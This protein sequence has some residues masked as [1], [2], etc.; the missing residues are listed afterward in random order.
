VRKKGKGRARR[1]RDAGAS[2]ETSPSKYAR[3]TRK[4]KGRDGGMVIE[5]ARKQRK[6]THI[7]ANDSPYEIE[8]VVDK[9]MGLYFLY[10]SSSNTFSGVR[11][12]L[13]LYEPPVLSKEP[14]EE[15]GMY[16]E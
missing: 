16:L 3:I 6:K 4:K 15:M 2:R 13:T 1:R 9:K 10:F 7:E 14:P 8:N 11:I 12:L 5:T